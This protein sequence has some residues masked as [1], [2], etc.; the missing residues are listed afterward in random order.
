MAYTIIESGSITGLSPKR[1]MGQGMELLITINNSASP[2]APIPAG[3][4]AHVFLNYAS[5]DALAPVQICHALITGDGVAT[6]FRVILTGAPDGGAP[7]G[8]SLDLAIDLYNAAG[9]PTGDFLRTTAFCSH[10]AVSGLTAQYGASAAGGLL[11]QI[12]KAV[13][14]VFPTTT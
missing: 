11:E 14:N 12:L 7:D 4:K 8:Q 10:D 3:Y 13:K 6:T 2:F 9:S 1:R 5:G